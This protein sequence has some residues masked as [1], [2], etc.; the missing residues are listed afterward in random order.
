[1][2][3]L[4]RFIWIFFLK[5]KSEVYNVFI[6]FHKFVQTQFNYTIQAFHF[7]WG[8]EFQ[9]VNQF[10]KSQG[11]IHRIACPHIHEKN[12]MAEQKIHHIVDIGLTLL[13]HSKVPL[14]F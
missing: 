3:D 8:G 11:I 9:K 4:T 13:A 5:N 14:K 1:M 10:L 2:D 6:N 12:G 7:D